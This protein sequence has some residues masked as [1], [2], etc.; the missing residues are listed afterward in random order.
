MGRF[1]D[2][3]HEYS[4]IH[5]ITIIRNLQLYHSKILPW[6]PLQILQHFNWL[7]SLQ[8]KLFVVDKSHVQWK[9]IFKEKEISLNVRHLQLVFILI[10]IR[11]LFLFL[12]FLILL[13][14]SFLR[15]CLTFI[16]RMNT[17]NFTICFTLY[18]LLLSFV[19]CFGSIAF[20][21]RLLFCFFIRE[22]TI[23]IWWLHC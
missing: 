8:L 2:A 16:R 9:V 22:R 20:Y 23:W 17:D 11:Q 14:I 10:T 1:W 4:L 15:Y 19:L 21:Y 6:F 5:L 18:L 13:Q 7:F 3:I 12:Q